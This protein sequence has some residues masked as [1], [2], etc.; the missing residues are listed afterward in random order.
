MAWLDAA[1]SDWVD[2]RERVHPTHM[3]MFSDRPPE[4]VRP[5]SEVVALLRERVRAL[6]SLARLTRAR[7][8]EAENDARS[9]IWFNRESPQG[10]YALALVNQL[11]IPFIPEETML[12]HARTS[13]TEAHRL[14]SGGRGPACI[15][16][17]SARLLA[18]LARY[19]TRVR[20][21]VHSETKCNYSKMVCG[22]DVC[23]IAQT[24]AALPL[25]SICDECGCA[26]DNMKRCGACKAATYC[27][28]ACQ[29][30]HWKA[31]HKAACSAAAAAAGGAEGG[32]G[33][34]PPSNAP[35]AHDSDVPRAI[36]LS[37]PPPAPT[38]PVVHAPL[39]AALS[40]LSNAPDA[41]AAL[42]PL[43]NAPDAPAALSPLSNAPAGAPLSNAPDAPAAHS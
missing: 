42:S 29:A 18:E 16:D 25:R 33:S 2:A 8:P 22:I 10:Y 30:R 43:S 1:L 41:P 4:T 28:V 27:N 20:E 24:F 6:L 5:A 35:D 13:A 9:L 32:S 36:A 14:A 19:A 39:A 12:L 15:R 3:T 34:S 40:P 37:L 26:G 7:L 31:G 11:L 17:A 38:A 23:N 21:P